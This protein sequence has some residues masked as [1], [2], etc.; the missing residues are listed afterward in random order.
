MEHGEGLKDARSFAYYDVKVFLLPSLVYISGWGMRRN[1]SAC[2]ENVARKFR[3]LI[4]EFSSSS[5]CAFLTAVRLH[6]ALFTCRQRF[7]TENE[8]MEIYLKS[9]KAVER[10]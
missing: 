4:F 1:N 10:A 6:R 7:S 5:F 3:N 2:D 9:L 8:N